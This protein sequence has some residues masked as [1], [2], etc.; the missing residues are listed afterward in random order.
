MITP[1]LAHLEVGAHPRMPLWPAETCPMPHLRRAPR[2]RRQEGWRMIL[3][4]QRSNPPKSWY[5]RS[6][7][8]NRIGL[9]LSEFLPALQNVES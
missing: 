4:T 8:Q 7:H 9:K 1:F 2:L 6:D 3:Q 5:R